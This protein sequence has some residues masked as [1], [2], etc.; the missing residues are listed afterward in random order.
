MSLPF[1]RLVLR[2]IVGVA[3]APL[4]AGPSAAE[5]VVPQ[6]GE[7]PPVASDVVAPAGDDAAE[8]GDAEDGDAEE[9]D[10][11]PFA[12]FV[13][14]LERIDGLLTLYRD[15][16]TAGVYLSIRPEQ[17]G[18]VYLTVVTRDAGDGFFY[19]SGSSAESFPTV[20]ERVGKRIRL[21]HRNVYFRADDG[22]PAARAVARGLTS[23]LLAS[24]ELACAVG[25]S[26]ELLVDAAPLFLRDQ[27]GVAGNISESDTYD[28]SFEEDESYFGTVKSFP[29][30]TEIEAVLEFSSSERYQ[31]GARIP[32]ARSMQH[33][34][35]YSISALPDSAYMPRLADERVGHFVTMYQD[36]TDVESDSAYRRYITRWRLEKKDPAARL[37][38]PVEPIVFW[39][40]NSVPVKY[41]AAVREGVLLWNDAFERV[42]FKNAV[43]VEQQPDD[44]DWDPAD[45]RYNT[46]RWMVMPGRAYAVGPSEANPFTGELYS[47]DIRLSADY[48]RA[49]FVD[50]E[51]Y[52]NPLKVFTETIEGADPSPRNDTGCNYADGKAMEATFGAELLA[53]RTFVDPSSKEAQQYVHDGL[54]D[55][56]VHEVGH[57]LGLRHNFRASTIHTLEQVHDTS[58]T[59]EEGVSG[60]VMDY[61]PVNIAKKG[62][63][64]GSFWCTSL[65]AY[66]Y[67]A[68]EYAYKPIDAKTPDEELPVLDGIASRASEEKFHYGT[69]EDAFGL[70]AQGIDP[71]TSPYDL[72][73]DPVQYYRD[74]LD[75]SDELVGLTETAFAVEGASYAKMR[76]VFGR[77]MRYYSRGAATVSKF[78]GG[79][80]HRR[81]HVGDPGDRSPLEPVDVE[82][83]RDALDFLTT[84]I[85]GE[86]SFVFR[87]SLMRHLA[88]ERRLDF[89]GSAWY[90]ARVDYPVHDL[91][92][93][94][95]RVALSR[96]YHP[97][98]LNRLVDLPLYSE[99][100][101]VL[102]LEE[103]MSSL[104]AAIW[105][106]VHDGRSVS[107][108]RRNLQREH[109]G[110]LLSLTVEPKGAPYYSPT[111]GSKP[112]GQMAPPADAR[113]LARAELVEI[114]DAIDEALTSDALDVTTRA[115]LAESRA[116]IDAAL[117]A[118]VSLEL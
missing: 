83:Q 51:E 114:G 44:A 63:R 106:E 56:V 69:D 19:D 116:R 59:E 68:I 118:S 105:A 104:A 8:T 17:L 85:F 22:S 27:G 86:S 25:D 78:V 57:T 47:A 93:S 1:V 53:A 49:F 76:R 55:L 34:W 117:E 109:L 80:H 60:S 107:S 46:I 79:I 10:E 112:A 103:M 30:N 91:V 3:L 6:A 111:S 28:Y 39:I 90:S 42:G 26:G 88:P 37:S 81:D 32:D 58:I 9:D 94:I 102:T 71:Y 7:D 108:F 97:I 101:D 72:G 87:A 4:A 38:E 50:Y 14:D 70:S 67:L 82:T 41:R 52:A 18:T 65:G 66:D 61:N 43:V 36:Y 13:A 35:R 2:V 62:E 23:S 100:S 31:T 84:R 21:V 73:S 24:S 96:L 16:E 77:A 115:H 29:R 48:V 89:E 74:R 64:Q 75:L 54:V 5:G 40:E 20:F 45:V 95:Q 33:R 15:P 92:L 99:R 12:E 98:K 11:T 110:H 113:A